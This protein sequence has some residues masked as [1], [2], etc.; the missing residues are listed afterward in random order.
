MK[1]TDPPASWA[2]D[3]NYTPAGKPWDA[4]PTKVAPTG[5]YTAQGH[6]PKSKPPAQNE[7]YI[8][9]NHGQWLAYL[10]SFM[11]APQHAALDF[12]NIG[13]ANVALSTVFDGSGVPPSALFWKFTA[14]DSLWSRMPYAVPGF[15][16]ATV[17]FRAQDAGAPAVIS[18]YLMRQKR[19]ASANVERVVTLAAHG[20]A[21]AGTWEDVVMNANHDVE[22]GY[23]YWLAVV[24]HD[25][26]QLIGA[27]VTPG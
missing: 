14:V 5:G 25:T 6:A 21:A 11:A 22:A 12:F 16:I 1:P 18:C 20:F 9:N 24:G 10:A 3:A 15:R 2:T 17:T 7:N 27:T 23:E 4:T 19:D 8:K 13:S 26:T